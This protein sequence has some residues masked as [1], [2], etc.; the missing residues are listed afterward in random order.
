MRVL[1]VGLG[2]QGRKRLQIAGNEAIG[3]VDPVQS[4]AD[5]KRVEDAPVAD[6]DAA[7]LCVPDGAKFELIQ[8]FAQHR[9]HVMVEKPLVAESNDKIEKLKAFVEK[10]GITYYTAYN[11]RFEPHIVRLKELIDSQKLGKIYQCSFSYGNGTARDVRNSAWRDKGWGVFPDL[12]SHL[13]DWT[14]MLF[15]KPNAAPEL[16]EARCFENKAYDYFHF[17]FKGDISLD[18]RMTLLSWRNTFRCDVFAE[19]GSAHIDCLCKWGPSVFTYRKRK[20]PSGRPDEESCTLVTP[21]PTWE[22]EYAHFKKLCE[23]PQHNMDHDVWINEM[24]LKI[25]GFLKK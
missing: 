12:G 10:Q 25:G 3:T 22:L 23:T 8:Y 1:I 5:Y 15:G 7:I 14:L 4:E 17:G 21:D 6:Y 24:F 2:I 13:L 9:K 18:Y 20:L 16:W 11:H 19:N